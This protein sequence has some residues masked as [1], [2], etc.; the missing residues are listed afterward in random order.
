MTDLARLTPFE[1]AF[2]PFVPERLGEVHRGLAM[3]EIDPLDRDAWAI[4]QPGASLLHELRP[5][6]GLGEA[7]SEL[8]ALAHAAFLYWQLGERMHILDRTRL[9]ALVR[10]RPPAVP[11][12]DDPLAYYLQLPPQRVWGSPVAGAA[13]EPLDGWFAVA[14]ADQLALV[15]VFGL[16]SGRPGFTVAHTDGP[17]PGALV[18]EDGTALFAS[19]LEGGA[20]AGLWSLVGEG[21]LLELGWRAHHLVLA[22]A[23]SA[24]VKGSSA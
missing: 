17:R 19:V 16:L 11:P 12:S 6:T 3:A 10:V 1:V 9:D 22:E 7:V 13:P 5:D 24:P 18:R 4:S 23:V 20:T 8:V 15:A 2:G 14:R 21:E